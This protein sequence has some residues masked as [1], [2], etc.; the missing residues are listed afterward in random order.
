MPAKTARPRQLASLPRAQLVRDLAALANPI[1]AAGVARYFKSGV[2]EYGEGDKFLGIPVPVQRK[3]V[4]RYR[5]LPLPDLARLLVSPTH[6]HRLAA[7]EILVA[8]Y[9]RGTE[10]ERRKIVAFYLRH[11]QGIN[12]WDLVDTSAPY[13]LGEHLRTRSRRL[14]VELAK[15]KSVWKR[16]MAIVSTLTLIK[17]GETADAFRIAEMLLSDP[18]DLIHKAVGWALRETGK[19]SQADLLAFLSKHYASIPRT[20]L[21]YAIERFPP[22]QRKRILRGQE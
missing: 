6:E 22:Q 4:L 1:R 13:I 12:N 10:M 5:A 3:V 11:P 17:S 8:Q 21:R 15:S 19:V 16:R 2:G 18:H 7:L 14:L 20:T 9:E